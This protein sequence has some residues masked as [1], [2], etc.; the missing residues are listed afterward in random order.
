MMDLNTVRK[1][2]DI[3]EKNKRIGYVLCSYS[4]VKVDEYENLGFTSKINNLNSSN[5]L[6]NISQRIIYFNINSTSSLL[7]NNGEY[8][9][10]PII[11]NGNINITKH[12]CVDI[13]VMDYSPKI[14]NTEINKTESNT[15]SEGKTTSIS[16]SSTTG[17]S[18]S[19]TISLGVSPLGP[20]IDVSGTYSQ[21]NSVTDSQD[22]SLSKN[23][24]QSNSFSMAIEDWG[25]YA[26]VNTLKDMQIG[27]GWD[28]GQQSPWNSL[29]Y[30]EI[31]NL[32]TINEENK[33]LVKLPNN[34]LSKLIDNDTLLPPSGISLYGFDFIMEGSF[35]IKMNDPIIEDIE[36]E[37]LFMLS[38]GT[39]K[40][41]GNMVKVY[42]DQNPSPLFF[43]PNCLPEYFP[44]TK[45]TPS[46]L[47]LNPI[48]SKFNSA[49]IGFFH[50][51]F[52][53]LPTDKLGFKITSF[54]NDLIIRSSEITFNNTS[55]Y[56]LI[57][58]S[59]C[60]SFS[61]EH[62]EISFDIFFKIADSYNNYN[63]IFKNWILDSSKSSDCMGVELKF[64]INDD[65][66]T[67]IT[68]IVNDCFREGGQSNILSFNLRNLDYQ[69]VDFY[70]Y[71]TI[72]L[73]K[74]SVK[75]RKIDSSIN[76]KYLINAISITI[77]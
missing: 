16:K 30:K 47:S 46:V 7:E 43:K 52:D 59:L 34:V 26:Y 73:N 39:H 10:Y 15:D 20:S 61:E 14:I 33:V 24:D 76:M 13:T 40:K 32:D 6:L 38:K 19:G 25:S 49:V 66:E 63:L 67:G 4:V 9:D 51:S 44:K 64:I 27:V 65:E 55:P 54:E 75:V 77:K 70:N 18:T 48:G 56:S 23:N 12:D 53:L 45:I 74:I 31:Y 8:K 35:L 11:L 72:G 5:Y 50:K 29:R 62:N 69:S 41:E 22:N 36:I 17:N 58:N 71:L 1:K 68:K 2:I 3:Y 37:H 60:L 57:K 42:K 28:F 21:D